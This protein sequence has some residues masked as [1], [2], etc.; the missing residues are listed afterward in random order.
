M[1]GHG[2]KFFTSLAQRFPY[3]GL[4]AWA[5]SWALLFILSQLLWTLGREFRQFDWLE[6][7]LRAFFFPLAPIFDRASSFNHNPHV[8]VY[9]LAFWVVIFFLSWGLAAKRINPLLPASFLLLSSVVAGIAYE[10]LT[11]TRFAIGICFRD[12]A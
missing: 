3:R 7:P 8:F 6:V 2:L 11:S 10:F 12:L 5:L 4:Q 9:A 1:R